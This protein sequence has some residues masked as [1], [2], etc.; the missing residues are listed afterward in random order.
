MN[1]RNVEEAFLW[2]RRGDPLMGPHTQ[3]VRPLGFLDP[4]NPR[5]WG[6]AIDGNGRVVV[7]MSNSLS[8]QPAAFV[9]YSPNF[10][11]SWPVS[12][13]PGI[14]DLYIRLTTV[15]AVNPGTVIGLL[16]FPEMSSRGIVTGSAVS[17]ANPFGDAYAARLPY[18]GCR[19]DL[20]FP[21]AWTDSSDYLQFLAEANAGEIQAD[22]DFDGLITQADA[23]AFL[24]D[25]NGGCN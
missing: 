23:I 13:P 6:T 9:W 1:P 11:T 24:N 17:L 3:P 2:S 25:W 12:Y 14:H 21:F 8:G 15:F 16:G 18:L 22:Y 10:P 20:A 7:G 5:S 4:S 19:T